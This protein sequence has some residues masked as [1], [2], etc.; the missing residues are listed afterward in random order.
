MSTLSKVKELAEEYAVK[1]DP[2]GAYRYS[3]TDRI[4]GDLPANTR[5]LRRLL[6]AI[7]A[8]PDS[9]VPGGKVLVDAEDLRV[10]DAW[11]GRTADRGQV[12][13][14]RPDRS[15]TSA[16]TR[17]TRD[18]PAPEWEPSDE[19]ME[20]LRAAAEE[21][22]LHFYDEAVM[23]NTLKALHAADLLNPEVTE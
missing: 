2:D 17:M 16:L 13:P 6:V 22:D 9:E 4:D 23:G 18:L 21:R 5:D 15:A 20:R 7:L 19:L 3:L 11:L 1:L 14:D 10:V 8:L 12:D